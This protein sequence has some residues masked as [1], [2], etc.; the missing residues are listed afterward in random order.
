[1]A[2]VF[3]QSSTSVISGASLLVVGLGAA[4]FA[5]M[6]STLI[7]LTAPEEARGLMMG[8]LTMCIGMA[9]IGFLHIGLLAD[10]LGAPTAIAVLAAEGLVALWW[11]L[12]R[13]PSLWDL[14]YRSTE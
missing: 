14:Q 2:I 6:Q 12:H 1:M 8:L 4:A 5:A 7:L 10:W 11:V 9:P 3:S 13:W